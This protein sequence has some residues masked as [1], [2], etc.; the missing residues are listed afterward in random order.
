MQ[1]PCSRPQPPRLALP[2]RLRRGVHPFALVRESLDTSL[3]LAGA[4]RPAPGLVVAR[5]LERS[6][7]RLEQAFWPLVGAARTALAFLASIPAMSLGAGS[8]HGRRQRGLTHG[9]RPHENQDHG[10]SN[11]AR[12]RVDMRAGGYH[13]RP[14]SS[15]GGTR[16]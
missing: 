16:S 7:D 8:G 4:S 6:A 10:V 3:D 14:W 2:R 11:G 12:V 1:R 15:T 13:P 5:A 9:V